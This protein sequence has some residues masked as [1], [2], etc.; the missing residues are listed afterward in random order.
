MS[1][2]KVDQVA[3]SFLPSPYLLTRIITRGSLALRLH[4]VTLTKTTGVTRNVGNVLRADLPPLLTGDKTTNTQPNTSTHHP[5]PKHLMLSPC[6]S[7]IHHPFI[8]S[9]SSLS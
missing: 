5:A 9:P 1:I 6:T 7:S 2:F 3:A 8:T 4:R